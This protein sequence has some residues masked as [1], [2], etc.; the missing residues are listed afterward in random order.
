MTSL[1][2]DSKLNKDVEACVKEIKKLAYSTEVK[3]RAARRY[4]DRIYA[5]KKHPKKKCQKKQK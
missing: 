4:N 1:K 3:Y 5:A 2:N